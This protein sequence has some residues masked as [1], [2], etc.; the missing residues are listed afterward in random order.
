MLGKVLAIALV[1]KVMTLSTQRE[2]GRDFSGMLTSC[3]CSTFP[4]DNVNLNAPK[5][6]T[7]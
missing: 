3:L 4:N 1:S 6:G 7:H 5:T 2:I